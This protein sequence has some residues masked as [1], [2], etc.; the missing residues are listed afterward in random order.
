MSIGFVTDS[1]AYLPESL[2]TQLAIEVVDVQVIVDGKTFD[3]TTGISTGEVATA[4]LARKA[5]TTSRPSSAQFIAA[6]ER[7]LAQG[8]DQIIS[9]H[10]S[11]DLSGT[12]ESALL[13]VAKSGLPVRVI[14]SRTIA[15]AMGFP[16]ISGVN[17]A[18][19]GASMDD[20]EDHIRSRCDQS[21]I[22]FYVDT[23]EFLKRGGRI[24]PVQ[25]RI[26]TA[27]SLK[28]L[29]TIRDGSI[30]QQ[31]LVRNTPKA[32]T[33]LLDIALANSNIPTDLAVLHVQAPRPA[34]E[35]ANQINIRTGTQDIPVIAAGAVVGAHLGPGALAIVC[36]P[37]GT[38]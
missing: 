19:S 36:S 31:E 6:Y 10:L 2:R 18:H 28:P 30:V 38:G 16:L 29:L 8:H 32:L 27:L 1:T 12:Y 9:L 25:S 35:L 34:Q 33:R 14:D 4:L 3:E 7:V 20:V 5:V 24:N 17:L 11:A 23:L 21:S 26:G 37:I 15:M 13:A 22:V